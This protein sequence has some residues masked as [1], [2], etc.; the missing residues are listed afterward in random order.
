MIKKNIGFHL[1]KSYKVVLA[2][3]NVKQKNHKIPHNI[4]FIICLYDEDINLETSRP[5]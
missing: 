5:Y 4:V 3:L 1:I 2:F